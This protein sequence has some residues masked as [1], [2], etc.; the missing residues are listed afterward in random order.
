MSDDAAL[1]MV[2]VLYICTFVLS[3]NV[4]CLYSSLMS[5]ACTWYTL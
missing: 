3:D 1:Y 5:F 2:I 4:E